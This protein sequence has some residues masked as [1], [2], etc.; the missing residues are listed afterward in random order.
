[1]IIPTHSVTKLKSESTQRWNSGTISLSEGKSPDKS[2]E[3]AKISKGAIVGI[4]V[5]AVVLVAVVVL[6]VILLLRRATAQMSVPETT[7]TNVADVLINED[8][9]RRSDGDEGGQLTHGEEGDDWGFNG[10]DQD[11]EELW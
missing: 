1:M 11:G 6:L 3:K 8:E 9:I 4:A 2:K 10:R 7:V 5:A